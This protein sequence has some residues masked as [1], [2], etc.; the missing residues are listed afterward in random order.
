MIFENKKINSVTF[1]MK[2]EDDFPEREWLMNLES[3]QPK[4]EE[5]MLALLPKFR[6]R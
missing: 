4:R 2:L 1:S 5:G 6:E 3:L